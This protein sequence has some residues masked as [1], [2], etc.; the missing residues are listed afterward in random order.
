MC[1]FPH[2]P[3][4]TNTRTFTLNTGATI[5]AIGLGTWRST[6]EEAYTSVLTAIK[7]GYRHIDTATAYGNEKPIGKAIA[8]SGVPRSELFITTKLAPIDASNPQKAIDASLQ[9]LGLDYVDLYLMHWPVALNPENKSDPFVPLLPNGKRDILL[10][11]SFVATYLD[12]Q[13]IFKQGKARAIGVSNFSVKNLKTLLADPAVEII[14]A[15]NQVELHPYLPLQKLVEFTKLQN[16][17][18]EA[19][20]PLGSTN[21]PLFEDKSLLALADK[22]GVS[23]ANIMISW[24]VWRDTVVL[25]KSS[26]PSRIVSNFKI[27]ALSD[28]DGKAIDAISESL[29]NKRLVNPD[30]SPV[31]VFNDD[32]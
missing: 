16:I 14:P 13:T 8:D 20:S 9:N 32:E 4:A 27:V 3:T 30:W 6:E 21:S 1:G 22:Y 29:G 23:A 31:V 7:A 18:L 17:A 11:R 2:I 28:E 15:V 24:A 26:N 5:P 25:P 19:Y 10:D 12:L